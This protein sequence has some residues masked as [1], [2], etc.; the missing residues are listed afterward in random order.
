MNYT[1]RLKSK[2]ILILQFVIII[3]IVLSIRN[4]IKNKPITKSVEGFEENTQIPYLVIKN[5]DSKDNTFNLEFN[6]DNN[7]NKYSYNCLLKI[8]KLFNK[9][10]KNNDDIKDKNDNV[11][12]ELKYLMF[13][14]NSKKTID[15]ITYNKSAD[16][17]EYFIILYEG[18]NFDG[19][20]ILLDSKETINLNNLRT[21]EDYNNNFKINSIIIK[22]KETIKYNQYLQTE[23]TNNNKIYLIHNYVQGTDKGYL[24]LSIDLRPVEIKL[25]NDTDSILKNSL[26]IRKPPN[27]LNELNNLNSFLSPKTDKNRTINHI[28]LPGNLPQNLA[29]ESAFNYNEKDY[30]NIKLVLY[31]K[32]IKSKPYIYK[33]D[34]I[35]SDGPVDIEQT[36]THYDVLANFSNVNTNKAKEVLDT[37]LRE[38]TKLDYYINKMI[39]DRYTKQDER[40]KKEEQLEDKMINQIFK[41]IKDNHNE[42]NQQRITRL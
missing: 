23:A 8:K 14:N 7:E 6:K 26:E 15:S 19:N 21:N 39:K 32:T 34:I 40:M 25:S 29:S 10:D 5:D 13:D 11:I 4:Y 41:K 3:F 27:F 36:I 35:N 12:T 30:R 18:K 33:D 37:N 42:I 1:D 31:N 28:I 2:T 22:K 16:S 17:T 24:V 9:K 38:L 20:F